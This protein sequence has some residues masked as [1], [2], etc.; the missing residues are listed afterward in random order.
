[1]EVAPLDRDPQESALAE[2]VGLADELGETRRPHPV[3]QR[4]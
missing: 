1:M 4:G 2:Q 3:S